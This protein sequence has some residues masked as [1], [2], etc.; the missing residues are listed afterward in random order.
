MVINI[1]SLVSIR[2]INLSWLS[3][4]TFNINYKTRID[5]QKTFRTG[6]KGSV[7]TTT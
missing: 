5:L 7:G 1:H 6:R 2:I 3:Q 4:T